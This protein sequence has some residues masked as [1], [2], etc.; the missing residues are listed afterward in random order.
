M[1][2]A[3]RKGLVTCAREGWSFSP[4]HQCNWCAVE[5]NWSRSPAGGLSGRTAAVDTVAAALHQ[6]VHRNALQMQVRSRLP[7]PNIVCFWLTRVCFCAG[8]YEKL[9]EVAKSAYEAA[10]AI[11]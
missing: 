6:I 8:N 2:A 5:C 1:L 3:V 11:L 7:V 4:P 9:G 10:A